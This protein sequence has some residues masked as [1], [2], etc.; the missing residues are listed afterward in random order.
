MAI[1]KINK[2]VI[3]DKSTSIQDVVA[4]TNSSTGLSS[5]EAGSRLQKF[6]SN[7][8]PDTSTHPIRSALGKFWAPVP[9]MLEAVI[10]IEFGLHEYIQGLVILVLLISNAVLGFFQESRLKQH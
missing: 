9:W 7:S 6:G 3:P 1:H 10:L 2:K 4:I 5:D 8:M